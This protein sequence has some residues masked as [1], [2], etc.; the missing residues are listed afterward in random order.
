MQVVGWTNIVKGEERR[1]LL[2]R[3]GKKQTPGNSLPK[4]RSDRNGWPKTLSNSMRLT[5]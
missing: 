1:I 4:T 3:M 5:V 2:R